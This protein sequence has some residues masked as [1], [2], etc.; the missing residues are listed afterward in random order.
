MIMVLG[1]FVNYSFLM[2]YVGVVKVKLSFVEVL[3]NVFLLCIL[4]ISFNFIA[5]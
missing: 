5:F 3:F 2:Y 4:F 1:M